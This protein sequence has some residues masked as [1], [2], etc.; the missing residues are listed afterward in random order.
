MRRHRRNAA[1]RRQ[2]SEIGRIARLARAI[3]TAKVGREWPQLT[4]MLARPGE[5]I[6]N[7][8]GIV[9]DYGT[10]DEFLRLDRDPS[11]ILRARAAR[12]HRTMTGRD[13]LSV[14]STLGLPAHQLGDPAVY[15]EWRRRCDQIRALVARLAV[16]ADP[17]V[18]AAAA[19]SSWAA[20]AA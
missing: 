5:Y 3:G 1:S 15:T 19:S 13:G 18:R 17:T 2:V 16:D 12:S 4:M 20:I 7:L 6:E 10:W 14:A 8:A 9:V 11:V